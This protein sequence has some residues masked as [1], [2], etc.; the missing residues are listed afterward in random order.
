MQEAATTEF[1]AIAEFEEIL[2][3]VKLVAKSV[4]LRA[5]S[6]S[7]IPSTKLMKFM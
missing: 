4:V 3:A 1:I 5:T 7:V 2:D 6:K